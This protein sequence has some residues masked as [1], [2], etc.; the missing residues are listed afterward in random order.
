MKRSSL[1]ITILLIA[2][3]LLAVGFA[4]FR[5]QVSTSHAPISPPGQT[6]W[7]C[8]M[9]PQVRLPNPG[10]C[11]ICS[12]PLIP[13]AKSASSQDSDP[14]GQENES[15]FIDQRTRMFSGVETDIV[16]RQPLTN[17]LRTVGRIQFNE[18]ALAEIVV[19]VDGYVERLFAD[20]TGMQVQRGD[21]LAEI[22]SPDL[23]V[24]QRELLLALEA[25]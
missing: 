20:F 25:G 9:H 8:S 5:Q 11:P 2:A 15:L 13:A 23:F 12:M 24:A 21:H 4:V 1:I 7:T 19:R 22:Y 3:G 10:K 17:E 6:V 16:R 14:S 18:S